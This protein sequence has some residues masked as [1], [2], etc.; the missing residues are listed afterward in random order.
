MPRKT[1]DAKMSEVLRNAHLLPLS[2]PPA[3]SAAKLAIWTDVVDSLPVGWLKPEHGPLLEQYVGHV[4]RARDL[5]E[6]IAGESAGTPAYCRLAR[7]AAIES[8]A[9]ISLARS[10]RLTKHSQTSA[11]EAG[12]DA[13]KKPRGTPPWEQ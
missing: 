5:D 12:T 13:A 3:L 8:R 7:A 1:I 11:E 10:L 4:E 6:L 9:I 2:P